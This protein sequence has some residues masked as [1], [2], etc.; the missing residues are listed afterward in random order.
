MLSSSTTIKAIGFA[1]A[2]HP[3]VEAVATFV[4]G[5]CNYALSATSTNIAATGGSGGFSVTTG[6]GCSWSATPNQS[7]LHTTSSGTSSGP[8]S[9]TVDANTGTARAGTI[10]VQGQTFTVTQASATTP[11]CTFTLQKTSVTL[12]AKGGSKNVKVKA[13]GTDCSW[14]AVSNDPF[15]TITEGASGTG[16]GTVY[17]TVPGNTN[18]TALSGTMT[19]AG[20]TFIVN[21][22]AGGCTFKLSPKAGKIKAAG[23]PAAVKVKPNLSDCDWTA[24]SNDSFITITDGASGIGKGTVSYT[25]AANTNTTA[26]TGSITVAGET[27]MVTQAGAK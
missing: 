21:Q 22:A 5:G 9:Y 26:L 8:V 25:V 14:T 18:T 20:Q 12:A 7:W 27:F 1:C 19:I 6:S 23:G 24:V 3:S 15:I 2:Y 10:T 13:R 17:Y 16:S 11:T 4:A